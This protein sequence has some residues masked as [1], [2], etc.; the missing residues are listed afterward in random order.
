MHATH[1]PHD[2]VL[3]PFIKPRPFKQH[4]EDASTPATF[5]QAWLDHFSRVV[6]SCDASRLDTLFHDDSWWRDHVALDWDL[7]TLRGLPKIISF[8]SDRLSSLQLR[9]FKIVTDGQFAPSFSSPINGLRWI[10][11]MFTFESAVG[12]GRGMIR[13]AEDNDE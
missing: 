13:L 2:V 10:E 8:L 9:S 11:S 12:R 6:A 5:A 1:H 4:F 3:T 7:H